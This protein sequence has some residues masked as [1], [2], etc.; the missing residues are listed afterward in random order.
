[1]SFNCA[2]KKTFQFVVFILLI[3]CQSRLLADVQQSSH[4][5]EKYSFEGT[6]FSKLSP[7]ELSLLRDYSRK[8]DRLKNYY[9]NLSMSVS[10]ESTESPR[11]NSGLF[12]AP[13]NTPLKLTARNDYSF[14]SN[15]NAGTYYKLDKNKFDL[16][17]PKNIFESEIGIVTPKECY[18]LTRKG[19]SDDYI[20]KRHGM[21]KEE[22][23]FRIYNYI[24][25]SAP[26][27]D[28][29]QPI[30]Y[31][32]FRNREGYVIESIKSEEE[33]GEKLILMTL[34]FKNDRGFGSWVY[35][36]HQGNWA[37][38][39]VVIES[40]ENDGSKYFHRQSCSYDKRENNDI[41]RLQK[42][43]VTHSFQKSKTDEERLTSQ[44]VFT[45]TKFNPTECPVAEIVIGKELIG[46]IGKKSTSTYYRTL[47]ILAGITLVLIC[48]FFNA[49]KKQSKN[50]S[51]PA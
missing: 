37:L 35:R 7:D 49:Y 2:Y 13:P 4:Q 29:G 12:L 25:T 16:S 1:M 11:D 33:S 30:E 17:D 51:E 40:N 10:E 42:C 28:L 39:D 46:D 47:S 34:S 6:T 18:F 45:V 32:L 24:F 41:P 38:K 22:F 43:V 8:Y 14:C 20:V 26:F 50:K 21:F 23:I 3:C 15:A 44:K 31:T 19:D 36:F 9:G 5:S 48:V 27:A